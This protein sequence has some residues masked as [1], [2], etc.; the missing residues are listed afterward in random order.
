MIYSYNIRML[1]AIPLLPA[2]TGTPERNRV[3]HLDALALLRALESASV[4]LIVTDPPYKDVKDEAWDRQWKTDADYIAW[5]GEHLS[6]WRRILKPNGS[7]YLFASPRLAAR[8]ELETGRWFNV[9][10]QVVWWKSSGNRNWSADKDMV[11][12][13]LPNTERI[14]FAE[15]YGSDSGFATE[16]DMTWGACF[17]PIRDWFKARIVEH[18]LNLYQLN[19]AIGTSTTGGGMASHYLGDTHQLPEE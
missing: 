13:F 3:Y 2:F 17:S 1:S 18:G 8:V 9:L 16:S 19:A 15:Q 6:E 7:L 5:L 12:G 4:D 10:N 11:R 14:I